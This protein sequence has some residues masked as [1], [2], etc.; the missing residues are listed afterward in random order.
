MIIEAIKN[1]RLI[2]GLIVLVVGV[3]IGA[4]AV[5][6]GVP[7]EIKEVVKTVEVEKKVEVEKEVVKTVVQVVEKKVYV[8]TQNRDVRKE[9]ITIKRPDGTVETKVV[10]EDKTKTQEASTMQADVSVSGNSEKEVSVK[11]DREALSERVKEVKNPQAQ[12]RLNLRTEVGAITQSVQ[13]LLSVGFGADRRIVGPFWV[14]VTM[15]ADMPFDLT[16]V[17]G[18][19]SVKGGVQLGLEF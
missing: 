2:H 14:G 1:N 9:T 13:P 3:A 11:T 15:S 16:G 19:H 4:S 7:A 12:W 17:H 6:F 18:L 10:V 5:R 8:K